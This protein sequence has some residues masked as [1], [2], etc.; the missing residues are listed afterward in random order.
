MRYILVILFLFS[1]KSFAQ[2]DK[3]YNSLSLELGAGIHIPM[4]PND[5]I[6]RS[7]YIAPR[8]FQLSGRYM[9][10]QNYGIKAHYSFNGFKNP[11]NKEMTLNY[12]RV[13]AEGVVNISNLIDLGY[14][15]REN[16]GIL[17]H[18]GVG[19]TFA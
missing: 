18:A 1:I 2:L 15:L 16:F 11:D 9:F 3:R 17:G 5:G 10:N 4:S 14:P 12:H 19:I 13:G 7:K 8:H 6:T